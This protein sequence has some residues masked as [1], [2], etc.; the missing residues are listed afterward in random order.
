[1]HTKNIASQ[2]PM[3]VR[4]VVS[5]ARVLRRP[6]YNEYH[7][8]AWWTRTLSYYCQRCGELLASGPPK[9]KHVNFCPNCG[10]KQWWNG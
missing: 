9:T 10:Q 8:T 1:M 2:Q 5:E 3:P 6:W 4:M 7:P